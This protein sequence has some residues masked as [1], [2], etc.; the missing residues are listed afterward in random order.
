[1]KLMLVVNRGMYV[2]ISLNWI[3]GK[4]YKIPWHAATKVSSWI[5]EHN[6]G[7]F[8]PT[9]GRSICKIANSLVSNFVSV[10]FTNHSLRSKSNK[11]DTKL[12]NS[13]LTI[14]PALPHAN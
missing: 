2:G 9:K 1:M 5:N 4:L 13:V 14:F 12:L 7:A 6:C 8:L 11:T 10:C 3:A